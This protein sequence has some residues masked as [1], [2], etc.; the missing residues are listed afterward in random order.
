[1][2]SALTTVETQQDAFQRNV[3]WRCIGRYLAAA[4][5]M[6][7]FVFW[8]WAFT[9]WARKENPAKLDDISFTEW[10]NERCAQAQ[11]M[12][13]ALPSARQAGTT[14]K[15]AEH[16]KEAT[17]HTAD[18]VHDLHARSQSLSQSQ[19][20]SG[21]T[22]P[23]GTPA[24][25]TLAEKI[26]EGKATEGLSDAALVGLWLDDWNIYLSDRQAHVER[27]NNATADTADRDL[28]FLISDVV[29]GGIY[30]RRMDGFA[31]LNNMPACQV[32]G[33]I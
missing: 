12:I 33:D 29:A 23:G 31:R 7:T 27:L 32:P 2:G 16:V 19:S 11:V 3:W 13:N 24:E 17:R 30:T 20:L 1:M 18:L 10:A 21:G 14:Q 22:H 8:I 6:S 9:P 26:A 5:V 15:R 4:F 25:D 28:R